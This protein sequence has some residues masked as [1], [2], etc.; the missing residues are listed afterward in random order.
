[1]TPAMHLPLRSLL[2]LLMLSACASPA[3]DWLGMLPQQTL[4]VQTVLD[5]RNTSIYDQWTLLGGADTSSLP[6]PSGALTQKLRGRALVGHG[7]DHLNTLWIFEGTVDEIL[8]TD[9]WESVSKYDNGLGELRVFRHNG[10]P[11]TLAEAGGYSLLCQLSAPVEETLRAFHGRAPAMSKPEGAGS[12]VVHGSALGRIATHLSAP[13]FDAAVS[14]GLAGLGSD[15]PDL[16]A[17][18]GDGFRATGSMPVADRPTALVRYLASSGNGND[19]DRL[20]PAE[21]SLVV[22]YEDRV[23]EAVY[24]R[25]RWEG[26]DPSEADRLAPMAQNLQAAVL[27]ETAF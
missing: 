10:Q 8:R 27:P 18:D 9:G 19:L 16:S 4:L 24:D 14:G 20:I 2:P 23:G 21:A 22:L 12:A 17:P 15:R 1:V 13:L 11:W 26:L 6:D 3:S 25:I 7:V 5:E